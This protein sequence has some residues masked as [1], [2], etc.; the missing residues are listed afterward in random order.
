MA[1]GSHVNIYFEVRWA[2]PPPDNGLPRTNNCLPLRRVYTSGLGVLPQFHNLANEFFVTS[3][4]PQLP[5]SFGCQIEEWRSHLIVRPSLSAGSHASWPVYGVPW[6]SPQSWVLFQVPLG[7][8]NH[9]VITGSIKLVLRH[10]AI[11]LLLERPV[12]SAPDLEAVKAFSPSLW[13][14]Q[15]Q[16][17]EY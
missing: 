13:P 7:V 12:P 1:D 5:E 10:R 9:D 2:P 4:L 15:E 3:V 17:S 16:C 8:P 14:Q 6:S 11:H